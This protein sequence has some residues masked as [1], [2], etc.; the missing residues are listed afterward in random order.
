MLDIGPSKGSVLGWLRRV[1]RSCTAAGILDLLQRIGWARERSIPASV[2]ENLSWAKLRQLA[3]RGA[4]HS[5]SHFRGFPE[6]KRHAILAAF[7]LYMMKELTDRAIDF[8][9]RL[10]GRTFHQ[11]EGQRW[12]EFTNK[13]SWVNEKLH[14]YSRL[15][16]ALIAA[17]RE[18]RDLGAAIEEV[19]SWETLDRDASRPA[20]WPSHEIRSIGSDCAPTSPSSGSTHPRFWKRS[21]SR[22]SAAIGPFW[23][24]LKCCGR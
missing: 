2:A 5:V 19:I 12:I 16:K 3:G 20:P 9:N 17:H 15:S 7:V 6:D 4:R 8:H 22:L 21:S 10:L 24:R 11:A 18:Q 1:P 13:G 23:R 14:N